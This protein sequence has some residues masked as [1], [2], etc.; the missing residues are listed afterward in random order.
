MFDVDTVASIQVAVE[1]FASIQ[2][3]VEAVTSIH[4]DAEMFSSIQVK[5]K[6]VA[7]SVVGDRR[8]LEIKIKEVRHAN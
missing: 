4:F 7:K 2:F 8:F 3:D 6:T 1:T 5:V